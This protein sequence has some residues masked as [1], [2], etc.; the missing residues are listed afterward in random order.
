MDTSMF[1]R[2][3]VSDIYM[4]LI[5]HVSIAQ[6]DVQIKKLSF[7]NFDTHWSCVRHRYDTRTTCVAQVFPKE[8]FLL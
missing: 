6:I 4:T 7:L 1:R 5:R 3:A 2:I 8:L